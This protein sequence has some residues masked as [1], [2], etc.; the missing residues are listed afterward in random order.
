MLKYLKTKSVPKKKSKKKNRY[1]QYILL[2]FLWVVVVPILVFF[3]QVVP[4]LNNRW[5]E[6]VFYNALVTYFIFPILSLII[7]FGGPTG[8]VIFI[9]SLF[10]KLQRNLLRTV[11]L[12]LLLNFIFCYGAGKLVVQIRNTRLLTT[13]KLVQPIITALEQYHTEFGKYP[14]SIT[15]LVPKYLDQIPTIPMVGYPVLEYE[16]LEYVSGMMQKPVRE[17]SKNKW[18]RFETGGYELRLMPPL[19]SHHFDRFVYWPRK[20]YPKY[21]YGGTAETIG[22]WVFIQE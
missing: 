7:L 4:F 5:L 19:G 15:D 12:M 16:K 3:I 2:G 8:L 11:G 9:V 13:A 14:S 17:E 18:V 1:V 10:Q 21:M 6:L 20:F 22:D